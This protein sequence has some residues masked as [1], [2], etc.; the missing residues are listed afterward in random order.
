[1]RLVHSYEVDYQQA[2][3]SLRTDVDRLRGHN[4]GYMD[5]IHAKRNQHGADLVA[6]LVGR[7]NM[8]CGFAN[9]YYG[10]E[11]GGFSVTAQ[12][13]GSYIFAHELG[14]NQGAHHDPGTNMLAVTWRVGA[15]IPSRYS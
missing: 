13:Y 3:D 6:L 4:D 15:R 11:H 9:I 5:E 1:M 14:H 10:S 7:R 2:D 8:Y 12:E